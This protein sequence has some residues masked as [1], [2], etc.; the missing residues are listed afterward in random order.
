MVDSE[1]LQ[2]RKVNQT[3][4][5][6]NRIF[7]HV[8]KFLNTQRANVNCVC[9]LDNF[10][11]LSW[12]SSPFGMGKGFPINIIKVFIKFKSLDL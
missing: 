11:Y 12:N 9:L 10:V 4:K 5:T 1:A 6:T 7:L 2:M 3:F 8:Y